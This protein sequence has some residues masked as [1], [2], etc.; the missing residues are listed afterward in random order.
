[1]SASR[2]AEW[3]PVIH[4]CGLPNEEQLGYAL[5]GPGGGRG[6]LVFR[7][8]HHWTLQWKSAGE[9]VREVWSVAASPADVTREHTPGRG[10]NNVES[11]SAH[12]KL[13]Q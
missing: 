1:M 8:P 6:E 7:H 2:L 11:M 10:N 4:F 12:L 5:Y 9:A 13:L 3:N